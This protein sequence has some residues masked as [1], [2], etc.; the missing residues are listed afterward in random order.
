MNIFDSIDVFQQKL[1]E[2]FSLNLKLI[3][4]IV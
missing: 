4:S 2:F 1:L 3:C